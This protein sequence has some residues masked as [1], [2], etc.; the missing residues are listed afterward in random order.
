MKIEIEK[1]TCMNQN[2]LNRNMNLWPNYVKWFYLIKLIFYL[3]NDNRN[4]YIWILL[5]KIK[6]IL[7]KVTCIINII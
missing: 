6:K 4:R 7:F 3:T 1:K 2:I 5:N